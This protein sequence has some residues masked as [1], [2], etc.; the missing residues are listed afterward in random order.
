MSPV[1]PELMKASLGSYAED[2]QGI[3]RDVY[4][5][6]KMAHEAGCEVQF[7]PEGY[8]RMGENFGFTRDLIMAAVE[9]GATV[10]N[11]PDTIGGASSL[12]GNDYFVEHM[13]RH[14]SIINEAFP[15][16]NIEWSVHCHNDYGLAVQN[17]INAVFDGPATQIEGCINGVGE[18][19]GNASLEQCIMLIDQ[20]GSN[21]EQSGKQFFTGV[22]LGKIQEISDFI[23]VHMLD[24]QAHWPVTG[25]NAARHSSGG[26][27]NA[28]LKNPMAYQ[29][30]DPKVVGKD[31]SFTF[32]PLSGGNHARSVIEDSGFI[33]TD[34]EKAKIA[35]F[36][37][38][39]SKDRR[40]DISDK[41]LVGFLF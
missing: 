27:T 28:I 37:K 13:K 26:H 11:C 29:P 38:D 3:V 14:C 30:F 15:Y 10:I 5:L 2:K 19:A 18:R 16:K 34:G 12:E 32:G 25:E 1:D 24:R 41:E 20:F 22:N 23:A 6:V 21:Q 8:S 9:G 33:C 17:T 4:E 40:K 36:I 39:R 31:I 7:S 35:Q